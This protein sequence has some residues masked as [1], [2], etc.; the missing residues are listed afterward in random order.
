MKKIVPVM[1]A[2]GSGKR[3]WPLSRKSYPK[4]FSSLLEE[5]SLFQKSAIRL[6]S[7]TDIQFEKH[8]TITH[9]DFRFIVTEQLQAIGIVPKHIILEPEGKNTAPAILAASIFAKNNNP[10]AILLVAPS[11]H[12]IPD[13][14]EFHKAIKAGIEQVQAGKMVVFG[15]SPT[16]PETGYGYIEVAS[17]N[18]DHL[19]VA[20]VECFIE[21]PEYLNAEKMFQAGNYLWNAG[22]FLFKAVDMITAFEKLENEILKLTEEALRV[23]KLDLGFYLLNPG[24]WQKIKNISIDIAIMER[25]KNLAVIKYSFKWSD[26]GNWSEVWLKGQK[27]SY[28]NVT[29]ET[30]HSIDCTETLL[31]S[32]KST[33]QIVGLGLN[34]IIAIAMPDAVLVANKNRT[35]DIKDVVEYLKKKNIPQA[36]IFQK[37]HRPWGWFESLVLGNGY[38]VKRICVN[39]GGALSLQSHKYR[40]EHWIVVKGIA[41]VTIGDEVKLINEGES[42]FVPK[43]VIHR[44]ENPGTHLMDLIEVQIGSYLKEDDIT[45]YED[46]YNRK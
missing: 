28:G 22:I 17:E 37:D 12:D 20:S 11:D 15:I 41:K 45:R 6:T 43:N 24:L 26:L 9:S 8:I 46:I 25:I 5:Q 7:S 4:Q 38:Q 40:S 16:N 34:N 14:E 36:E 27:D 21:K 44:M 39:P 30:A 29:S 18:L 13:T 33:I 1:L 35:Q 42:V 19:G 23:A 3:L 10:D 2:G 31:R 32:E